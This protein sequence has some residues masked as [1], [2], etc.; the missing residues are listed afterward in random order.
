M[1]V[2]FSARYVQTIVVHFIINAR[3]LLYKFCA[4]GPFCCM[5]YH[6]LQASTL[7]MVLP[8]YVWMTYGW[9]PESFWELR[10][11]NG[12][13][14]QAFNMCSE[15]QII[16]IVNEMIIIHHYPRYDE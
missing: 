3:T 9:Y 15:E 1:H 16:S 4:A 10:P 13:S 2:R 14:Y 5:S 8:R 12:T 11:S 6:V 7:G